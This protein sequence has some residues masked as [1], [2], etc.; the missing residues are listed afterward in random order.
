MD[1]SVRFTRVE[2]LRF[3]AFRD[4]TF[5][6]RSFNILVGP[7]NAGKSTILAAFRILATGMR[8]AN[9]RKAEVVPGPNGSTLGYHID[10]TAISIAEENIFYN[11]DNSHSA[12][13]IFTLSNGNQLTLYF[14]TEG[15]CYLIPR[16]ERLTTGPT[17]FRKEFN[18]TIGFSPILGPVDHGERLYEKEAAR[19]ALFNYTA[20]R[21]FRNIW[22]HY[23]ERFSEFREALV[24]TWPG[25]DV[26]P[27]EVNYDGAKPLL[28]MFCPEE[29]IPR[30]IFWAGFGF[31]VWCQMLTHVIQS[32]DKSIFLIDE[33]DIYLHSDL[34][35]QLL[36]PGPPHLKRPA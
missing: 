9:Q 2:F 13:V 35:R 28:H 24:R 4:F 26:Q 21:N 33:P 32:D 12:S 25:M 16:G 29:R 27:P 6:V 15:T 31:Q 20:S 10:I 34:Q 23:P 36:T 17:Q 18:C 7:N 14:D 22:H 1:E 3:K 30:E 5:S 19:L 11:Y 8:K